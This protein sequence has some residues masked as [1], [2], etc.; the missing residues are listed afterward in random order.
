MT[1]PTGPRELALG[2]AAELLAMPKEGVR[3]LVGA[4]YLRAVADGPDGPRFALGDVKGFLARVS[5]QTVED[6][7]TEDPDSVDPQ[8]LLDALDGRADEMARRA[9]EIFSSVFPES[10]TW[11]L[12]EQARF[13]EQAKGRFEAILAVT[14]QGAEVD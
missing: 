12:K 5:G 11:T 8:A 2:E 10:N 14:G 7:F 13:I 4:G 1:P 9:F 3:A 6:L